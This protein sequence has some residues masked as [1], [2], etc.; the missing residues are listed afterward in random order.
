ME[1][2]HTYYTKKGGKLFQGYTIRQDKCAIPRC[3]S[4]LDLCRCALYAAGTGV[5]SARNAEAFAL[6]ITREMSLILR[7]HTDSHRVP[8]HTTRT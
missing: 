4:R 7:M 8:P 2:L 5:Q 1:S 3:L 6:G